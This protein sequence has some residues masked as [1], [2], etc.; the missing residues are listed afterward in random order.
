MNDR[1]PALRLFLE[2]ELTAPLLDR[3]RLGKIDVALIA[4]PYDIEGLAFTI[5]FEDEFI[6]A[7]NGHHPLSQRKEVSVD[8]LREQPLMLLEEGHC[9][10]THAL[11][12]C[13]LNP[14][15][16]RSKFEASSFH[17][18][19]QMV[20]SGIGV[21]LL[22]KLAVDAH[23]TNG[24]NIKLVPLAEASR[25]QIGLVWRQSSLR[26]REFEALGAAMRNIVL[27]G[28]P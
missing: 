22:P 21:T 28:S 11:A 8:E 17:T 1:Y 26:G 20:A 19:V 3:L 24:I 25:R 16:A 14:S 10:R 18:L 5:L 6:F 12:A 15:Q 9:L 7:C 27:T 2:E 13:K 4:M 23:I